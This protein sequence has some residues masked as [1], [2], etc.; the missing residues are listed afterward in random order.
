MGLSS[1]ETTPEC[2]F[3]KSKK[4]H[5]TPY[6]DTVFNNKTFEYI[7]CNDCGLVYVHP[8]PDS[9]DLVKMY[10]VEYQGAL[11]TVASGA[12]DTLFDKIKASGNYVTLL[13][14][15]CGGG[16]FVAEALSKG[17][18]VTGVEYNPDLVKT[19]SEGFPKAT[20]STIDHFHQSDTKYDIIFLSNV[21]EH[22]T[23]PREIMLLLKERL[24]PN[25]IF[26][27]EGPVENNFN[28]TKYVRKSMFFVRKKFFGKKASH[29]PTHVLYADRKNQEG[30]LKGI[31][32]ETLYYDIDEGHWPFPSNYK[33]CDTAM[34]KAM[35]VIADASVKMSRHFSF[36]GN[37]FQYIGK[38]SSK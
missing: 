16:R 33:D 8:L 6:E 7:E 34:K 22:L 3:C 26:V 14:Y 38:I 21:L 29:V 11:T 36:W 27:L 4:Y 17:Y 1:K 12:Y 10:P 19:L 25:G 30:F 2:L 31:G 18:T 28:L 13:D 23:N 15:G 5:S 35:F 32:L 37:T 24:H 20:F 9:D